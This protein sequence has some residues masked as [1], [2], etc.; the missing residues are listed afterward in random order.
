MMGGSFHTIALIGRVSLHFNNERRL[1]K[2]M[3]FPQRCERC[4][5]SRDVVMSCKTVV[6]ACQANCPI[7]A[8]AT[9]KNVFLP[10][11][12]CIAAN[13]QTNSVSPGPKQRESRACF[14]RLLAPLN[15]VFWRSQSRQ[16][17]SFPLSTV[18]HPLRSSED[19]RLASARPGGSTNFF[20]LKSRPVRPICGSCICKHWIIPRPV[21]LSSR[22][23]LLPGCRL[24]TA[25]SLSLSR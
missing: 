20:M 24:N 23:V 1:L 22:L 6:A 11:G 18:D 16:W 5:W 19:S 14:H 17:G 4:L 15:F 25:H 12:S 2:I 3:R 21:V 8:K 10:L 7:T 9:A 13:R